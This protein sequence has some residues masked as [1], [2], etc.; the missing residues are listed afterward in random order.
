MGTM[1]E[2]ESTSRRIRIGLPGV[3]C[4]D[5]AGSIVSAIPIST[6]GRRPLFMNAP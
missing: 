3:H 6:M 5:A 2:L 1:D 4:A